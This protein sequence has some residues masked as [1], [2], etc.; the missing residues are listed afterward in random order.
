VPYEGELASKASHSDIVRNPEV[1][2]FLAECQYLRPPTD[3]EAQVM[4][5]DFQETPPFTDEA[6]PD[7]VMSIDGSWYEASMD[8][9]LPS[10]KVAYVKI[11][12]VLILMEEFGALRVNGGP[13]VDPFRVARL[14]DRNWPLTM[15]VPSANVRWRGATSVRDS[16]REAVDAH[17]QADKTRFQADDPSTSLRA[18]LTYLASTRPGFQTSDTTKL[19]LHKCPTCETNDVEVSGAADTQECPQ[20]HARVFPSDVLRLWQEVGEFQ[21]NATPLT[22][23]MLAVE[24]LLPVHF[25]GYLRATSPR[26]LSG[27]T[28]FL[29]GPLAVFGPPAWL[30]AALLRYIGETNEF[31]RGSDLRPVTVLGL[32]KTGQVVDHFSLMDRFLAPNRIMALADDYRY[33]SVLSGRDP[34]EKGF[35]ENTYYGQDFL[36]KTPSGRLFVFALPYP[37]K[38]KDEI[39]DFINT[40]TNLAVYPE[41]P[42]ALRLITHF[43]SDL[44]ANAVVPIAL[45]HR[46]TAI[47]LVPGG[48][49]LDLLTE[50]AFETR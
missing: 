8:D 49:V 30:H 44:Y 3:E 48:K 38:A 29:D 23:F 14:E 22:R 18:T 46:Y 16:F 2:A 26:A 34:A 37:C 7:R 11:G 27:L 19:V 25:M 9:R 24:H 43:E 6:L 47:S 41:L 1:A 12:C 13:F 15:P 45:A 21:S 36:F 20:C 33:R 50:Q 35:G 28:F 17:L 4:K 39:D 5:A 40:K 42:R 10:T 32:Q 31:L